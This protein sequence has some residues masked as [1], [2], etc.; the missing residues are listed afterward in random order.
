MN[1]VGLADL[2][3]VIIGVCAI[4]TVAVA[5]AV[6]AAPV[7][8]VPLA[9]AVLVMG[10]PASIMAWVMAYVLVP[11]VEAPGARL[12]ASRVTAPALSSVRV[13]GFSV[14]LPVLVTV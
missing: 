6:T 11:V 1:T 13:T 12:E 7:G 5:V 8:G 2:V 9:V 10:D 3:S 4:V 14:T